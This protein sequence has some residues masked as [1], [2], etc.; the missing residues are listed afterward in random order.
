MS[1]KRMTKAQL[2]DFEWNL[3][4][5]LEI[6]MDEY[7]PALLENGYVEVAV[8]A[9]PLR[10][11]VTLVDEVLGAYAQAIIVAKPGGPSDVKAI[12]MVTGEVVSKTKWK[13]LGSNPALR[14]WKLLLRVPRTHRVW[15]LYK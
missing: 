14:I 1:K 2:E 7:D 12:D 5:T 11:E 8:K 9:R 13:T 15:L 4:E 10:I 3:E 6:Y